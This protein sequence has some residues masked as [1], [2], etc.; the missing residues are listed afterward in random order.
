M[1]LIAGI[2]IGGMPDDATEL[3]DTTMIG[4]VAYW[5]ETDLPGRSDDVR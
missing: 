4:D 2:A 5:H 3:N 1:T